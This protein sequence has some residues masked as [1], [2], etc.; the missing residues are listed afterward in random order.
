MAAP[1][2]PST[3]SLLTWLLAGA[4]VLSVGVNLYCLTPD[5]QSVRQNRMRAP[6]TMGLFDGDDDDE[7]QDSAWTALHE[8]LRQT[9][10]RLAACQ[11]QAAAQ[12]DA[13]DTLA[14]R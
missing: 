3:V 5:Y 12:T 10:Q 13:A 1:V 7:E 6:H 11:R 8:E 9:R 2:S 14:F 4:L